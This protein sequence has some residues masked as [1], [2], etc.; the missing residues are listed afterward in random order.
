MLDILCVMLMS[1]VWHDCVILC[2][3]TMFR[4][5]ELQHTQVSVE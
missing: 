2:R 3:C 4:Y 1:D 5:K